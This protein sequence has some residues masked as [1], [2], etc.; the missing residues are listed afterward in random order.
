MRK[1][2]AVIAAL[3]LLLTVAA[4]PVSAATP[5][6]SQ[7]PIFL[8]FPDLNYNYVVFWNITRDDFCAWQAGGFQGEPPVTQLVPAQYN[9]TPT[10]PVIL[11]W[12]ATSHIELWT[13]DANAD[14]S[15]PCQDTDDST[16]PWA[17]GT[18]RAANGD[19]DLSHSDSV[20]AGL[21]RTDS[22]GNRGEG[23]V[24]DANGDAW[25]YSWVFRAVFDRNLIYREV[26]PLRSVLTRLG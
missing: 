14:L 7:D 21:N 1:P 5:E 19:N 26:V 10:G 15:G 16:A 8:I 24:W 20:A 6:R 3:A 13:L 25:H 18:A 22:F 23:T 9:E 2:A 17:V 4:V 12:S 11:S